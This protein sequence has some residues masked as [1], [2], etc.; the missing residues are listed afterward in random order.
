MKTLLMYPD[1]AFS[2][3]EEY[4]FEKGLLLNDLELNQILDAMAKGDGDMRKACEA[5]LLNYCTEERDILYRQEILSELIE[6]PQF[7]RE[8][9][10]VAVE[11][12]YRRRKEHVWLQSQMNAL[13][14]GAVEILRMTMEQLKKLRAVADSYHGKMKKCNKKPECL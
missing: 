2:V 3:P 6:T 1:R 5:A 10:A 11:T 14:R 7:A 9:Y 4:P 8:M 13:F 12:L